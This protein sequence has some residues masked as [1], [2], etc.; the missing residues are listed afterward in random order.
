MTGSLCGI[1]LTAFRP[2]I[3]MFPTARTGWEFFSS[4]IVGHQL[5][6]HAGNTCGTDIVGHDI[7]FVRK[8]SDPHEMSSTDTIYFFLVGMSD[9]SLASTGRPHFHHSCF[10][11]DRVQAT[12]AQQTHSPAKQKS[13][14]NR[15]LINFC[16]R[17]EIVAMRC[18]ALSTE[19]GRNQPH[20]NVQQ[21]TAPNPEVENSRHGY[22]QI[23]WLLLTRTQGP[24]HMHQVAHV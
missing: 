12:L 16:K 3:S 13:G 5:G 6:E 17:G 15:R 24:C 8:R 7:G 21:I 23:R 2:R 1:H 20:M 10:T 11:V 14:R 19:F 9:H 18:P 22:T 4:T